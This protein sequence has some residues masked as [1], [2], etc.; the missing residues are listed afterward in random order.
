MYHVFVHV[1]LLVC[2]S[3]FVDICYLCFCSILFCLHSVCIFV[4]FKFISDSLVQRFFIHNYYLTCSVIAFFGFL[5]FPEFTLTFPPIPSSPILCIFL[6]LLLYLCFLMPLLV[7]T[8]FST[9]L[10]PSLSFSHS[11][12]VLLPCSCIVI[13][14]WSLDKS[15]PFMLLYQ[16]NNILL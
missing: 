7:F 15:M 1:C 11:Y 3:I 4:V 16:H 2:L 5:L 6:L 12:F 13:Y 9:H 10:P 14:F 8:H